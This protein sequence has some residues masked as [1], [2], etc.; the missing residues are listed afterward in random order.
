MEDGLFFDDA[1]NAV[2]A[3]GKYGAPV[4]VQ[5]DT[6]RHIQS[7]GLQIARAPGKT[8]VYVGFARCPDGLVVGGRVVCHPVRLPWR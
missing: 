3:L 8:M 4:F 5:L 7:T 6:F 2:T 1:I